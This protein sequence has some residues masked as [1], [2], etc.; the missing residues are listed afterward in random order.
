[1][2]SI[3]PH[4]LQFLEILVIPLIV[5][6][7][8]MFTEIRVLRTRMDDIEKF[9]HKLDDITSRLVRIETIISERDRKE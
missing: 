8:W 5:F 1:M 6:N 2:E 4:V 3:I 9:D 7:V